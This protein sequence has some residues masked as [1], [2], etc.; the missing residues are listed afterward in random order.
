MISHRVEENQLSE[1]IEVLTP[2]ISCTVDVRDSLN[3]D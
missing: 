2:F 1:L 3:G